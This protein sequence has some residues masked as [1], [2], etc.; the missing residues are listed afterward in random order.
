MPPG[1]YYFNVVAPGYNTY[2][3]KV[4]V[5]SEGGG[6][7]ENIELTSG[8]TWLSNIDWKTVLLVVVLLLLVYNLYRSSVLRDKLLNLSKKNDGK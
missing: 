4:F 6:I 5:V 8:R 3:G 2:E 1:S 7:H